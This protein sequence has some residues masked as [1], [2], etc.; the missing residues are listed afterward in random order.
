MFT[1]NYMVNLIINNFLKNICSSSVYDYSHSDLAYIFLLYTVNMY[2]F[3]IILDFG[4]TSHN[5]IE[6]S[7]IINF[8]MKKIFGGEAKQNPLD[9]T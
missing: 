6:Q 3:I 8:E 7:M 2:I 4:V 1:E 5:V 9:S